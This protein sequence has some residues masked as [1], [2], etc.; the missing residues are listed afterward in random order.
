MPST[1][2]WTEATAGTHGDEGRSRAQGTLGSSDP[3]A[4]PEHMSPRCVHSP[5]SAESCECRGQRA[6]VIDPATQSEV[7]INHTRWTRQRRPH[8]AQPSTSRAHAALGGNKQHSDSRLKYKH[9]PSNCN[10][11]ICCFNWIC[12]QLGLKIILPKSC[13]RT[14]T[15]MAEYHTVKYPPLQRN[16]VSKHFVSV[17]MSP[18][19]GWFFR[20]FVSLFLKT[21]STYIFYCS[22]LNILQENEN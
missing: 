22:L 5:D 21:N 12:F 17:F 15:G 13:S 19:F 18:A 10:Y 1:A 3:A 6:G 9:W 16:S 14:S 11:H 8:K 20:C 4:G 2:V 7:S